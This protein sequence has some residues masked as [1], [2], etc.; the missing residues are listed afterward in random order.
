[1]LSNLETMFRYICS[2]C[3]KN[4]KFPIAVVHLQCAVY[5]FPWKTQENASN[6]W[7]SQQNVKPVRICIDRWAMKVPPKFCDPTVIPQCAMRVQIFILYYLTLTNAVQWGYSLFTI[8]YL[9]YSN[10][11]LHRLQNDLFKQP[12]DSS[13]DSFGDD[14]LFQLQRH[15]ASSYSVD[16]SIRHISAVTNSDVGSLSQTGAVIYSDTDSCFGIDRDTLRGLRFRR[17]HQGSL[18]KQRDAWQRREGHD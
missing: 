1:M 18:V 14:N 16:A 17:T 9:Y 5:P 12:R 11:P 6:L 2:R 8:M 3:T 7:N 13:L 15:S 4:I 10:D